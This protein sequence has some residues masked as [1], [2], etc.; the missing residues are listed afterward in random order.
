MTSEWTCPFCD[1]HSILSESNNMYERVW[2]HINS[3]FGT[4]V[5]HVF[6]TVC[7]NP[8]CKRFTIS[9]TI[10]TFTSGSTGPIIGPA[11]QS[12][13]LVPPSSAKVFPVYVP[14]PIIEDY[15]EACLIKGLSPKASA[16]LSRRCLQGMIRD[17]W[18]ITKN[19]LIDEI[20]ELRGKV[21][22][23]TWSA[24]DAVRNVG[25]IGAHMEKD[26]NLIIDVEPIEAAK[27]IEL[28]EVLVTDWYIARHN[29]E[30]HLKQ[31]VAIG[32]AKKDAAK[33][34]SVS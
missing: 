4:K 9:I 19:R 16:A 18:K 34:D 23:L 33:R 26:I 6:Y 21:D 7:S 24:I 25:N 2:C 8:T 20:E 14:R 31:V 15:T 3:A 27:L 13:S 29:R 5:L 32:E 10:A 11:E 30:E 22:S 28:I 17:F 1:R 12:W